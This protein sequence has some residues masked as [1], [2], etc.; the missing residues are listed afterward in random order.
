MPIRVSQAAEILQV[1]PQTVRNFCNMGKLPYELNTANQRVFKEQDLLDFKRARLGLPP[2]TVSTYF[3]VRTSSKQD[4]SLANQED[5]LRSSYGEPTAIFKDTASGLSDK[6]RGLNKLFTELENT[7]GSKIVYITNKD[8]LTRFNF[9]FLE[10]YLKLLN[11]E[12]IIL[13][14]DETKEPLEVLMQDFMSLLAS[15][16]GKFYRLRG[17][18]QRRKFLKD[19]Q[20]EVDKH[21][22]Q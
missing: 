7:H 20:D 22:K 9:R 21:A 2:E 3:Y 4:V 17:W 16:S 18:D 15:F 5:K 12:I 13:D 6:R 1:S 14:S 10:R 8:R 19:V 11:T